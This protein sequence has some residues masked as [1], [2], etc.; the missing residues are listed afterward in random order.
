MPLAPGERAGRG[1]TPLPGCPHVL[2]KAP[3]VDGR[4][5]GSWAARQSMRCSESVVPSAPP[6]HR[7]WHWM[8]PILWALALVPPGTAGCCMRGRGMLHARPRRRGA[9]TCARGCAPASDGGAPGRRSGAFGAPS[10]SGATER[11]RR[12]CRSS[13]CMWTAG[14]SDTRAPQDRRLS[15]GMPSPPWRGRRRRAPCRVA[16]PLGRHAASSIP[17]FGR[18]HAPQAVAAG[19]R[20]L[21]REPSPRSS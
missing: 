20:G 9:M 15:R 2:G 21:S 5:R 17:L 19:Q 18:R 13:R 16:G 4:V 14:P 6:L 10:A 1:R 12:A 8:A 7:K 3:D 11:G